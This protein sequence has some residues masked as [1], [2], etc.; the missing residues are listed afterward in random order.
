M[1]DATE[2]PVKNLRPIRHCKECDDRF[3]QSRIDQVFCSR[4]CN[5]RYYG[6]LANRG[7]QVLEMLMTWRIHRGAKGTPGEGMLTEIAAKVDGFVAEDRAAG[8]IK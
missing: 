4:E 2:K 3:M 1:P 8:R 6:R 7:A 5:R